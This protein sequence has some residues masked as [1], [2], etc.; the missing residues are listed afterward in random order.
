MTPFESQEKENNSHKGHRKFLKMIVDDAFNNILKGKNV[1]L[2]KN[3]IFKDLKMLIS[4]KT[5]NNSKISYIRKR[6]KTNMLQKQR[7]GVLESD[8]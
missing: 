5:I 4:K 7:S 6:P 2:I 1:E 8:H 3:R